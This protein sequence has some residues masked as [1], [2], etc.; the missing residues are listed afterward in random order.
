MPSPQTEVLI[1]VGGKELARH[2]FTPG[3]YLLGRDAGC[4][5]R[6]D[7]DLVSRQHAKLILNYDH[8]LTAC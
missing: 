2:L 7:A 4:P 1:T 3:D 6:V 8:A 5:I